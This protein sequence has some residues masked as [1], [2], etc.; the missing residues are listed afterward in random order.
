MIKKLFRRRL[1]NFAIAML[2]LVCAVELISWSLVLVEGSSPSVSWWHLLTLFASALGLTALA[3]HRSERDRVVSLGS[4][5]DHAT[6][7]SGVG[8]LHFYPKSGRWV[9]N[10]VAQALLYR[11]TPEFV[12]TAEELMP[13]VHP[14][15]L[16]QAKAVASA[17]LDGSSPVSGVLRLGMPKEGFVRVRYYAYRLGDGSIAIS[18]VDVDDE[19]EARRIA[20]LNEARLQEALIAARASRVELDFESGQISA[21]AA[22]RVLLGIDAGSDLRALVRSVDSEYQEDLQLRL[23]KREPFEA[24]YSIK[25]AS[26]KR[27]WIRFT[28]NP[29]SGSRL[30]L[31]LVDLSEQKEIEFEQRYLLAQLETAS[32]LAKISIYIEDIETGEIQT[33]Y[34]DPAQGYE[35]TA[36]QSLFLHVPSDYHS[37]IKEARDNPGTSAEFPFFTDS[38]AAVWLRYSVSTAE[39]AAHSRGRTLVI[40]DVS[41]LASQREELQRSLS[42][43]E[44][45]RLQLQ[46]RAE[47]EHQMFAVIGHELRTPAASIKML[48]DEIE[49]DPT[50]KETQILMDQVEHLLDVLDDVRML[51][52]PDRVYQSEARVLALRPLIARA[53]DSLAPLSQDAKIHVRLAADEGADK[54]YRFNPQILR[55]LTLNLIRNACFHSGASILNLTLRTLE[56]DDLSTKV[57]LRVED[58]GRGVPKDFQPSL[59]V[60]FHREDKESQGMG[61]GLSI[62]QT[63]VKRF[64]GS[65]RYEDT[66]GG[67]ATF[68]VEF[69]LNPAIDENLIIDAE[70]VR[71]E[72]I[73]QIPWNRLRVLVAEDNPTIRMLTEKILE[74]KGALVFS[75]ADGQLALDRFDGNDINLVLTDIFMP[76]MD[77]YDLTRALREQKFKGPIIGVSAAVVG[78][79]TDSLLKAGA[80]LVLSKPIKLDEL[81]NALLQLTERL[82]LGGDS[83]S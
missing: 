54:E 11:S 17:A 29:E 9:A 25:G 62:C 52:N 70:A 36:G 19:Y 61:L 30:N 7:L 73:S 51:V 69:V 58:N 77:G 83:A 41:D 18:L 8:H 3:L 20:G 71:E 24:I 48:L 66:P 6:N 56:I 75:G 34:E 79:E 35:F 72:V 15:D 68:V 59:F 81:N 46:T 14:D 80:D 37:A 13:H 74:T 27:R 40:Q 64:H 44:Q 55:Q 4:A 53:I 39:T 82:G 26:D 42:D 16:L 50:S 31:T 65:I 1:L 2:G 12:A 21:P 43:M 47:R 23:D 76:T 78:E 45:V 57:V 67:G 10:H 60:P 63:L 49:L 28:A 33:V 22:A 38:G 32:K 5:L